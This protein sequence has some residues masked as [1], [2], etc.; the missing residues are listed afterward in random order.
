MVGLGACNFQG[1][2]AGS[3][4]GQWSTGSGETRPL[5]ACLATLAHMPRPKLTQ[6]LSRT[7]AG[8]TLVSLKPEFPGQSPGMGRTLASLQVDQAVQDARSCL[9]VRQSSLS[10]GASKL[11]QQVPVGDGCQ[12]R[13]SKSPQG[14]SSPILG[15]GETWVEAGGGPF[16]D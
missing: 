13:P 2:C 14:L 12:I 16:G 10:L 4:G 6:A 9:G 3:P 8:L 7:M 5:A 15:A 11:Q 1:C